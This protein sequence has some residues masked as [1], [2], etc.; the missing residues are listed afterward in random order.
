MHISVATAS[1]YFFSFEQA[2]EIIA[3]AGFEQIELD[4]YWERGEWAM[5][6]HLKGLD[7]RKVVRM[8][9]R[10]GLRVSSIHDGGGVIED[11]RTVHLSDYVD[12]KAHVFVGDGGLDF[13][14]G[15]RGL[16]LATL[17]AIT[18]ECSVGLPGETAADM[19]RGRIVDRLRT[20]G[21]RL[22]GWIGTAGGPQ[23]S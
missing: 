7:V 8:V 10:S 23:P 13:V 20:A 12:G 18:L 16:D 21:S 3:G 9:H 11:S 15:F 2:L 6:Q 22:R 14:N 17:H 19:G 5:A 1:F 4:L